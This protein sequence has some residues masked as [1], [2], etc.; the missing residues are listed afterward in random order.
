MGQGGVA[1]MPPAL[2]I[3][4]QSDYSGLRYGIRGTLRK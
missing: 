3:G 4:P 1:R 2:S